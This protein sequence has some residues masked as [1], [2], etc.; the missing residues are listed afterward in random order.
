MADLVTVQ[1]EIRPQK[2]F[3]EAFLSSRA[4][5]TIGGGAAGLGKTWTLQIAP[6]RHI[7]T[8]GFNCVTFRRTMEQIKNPGSLWDKSLELYP[9][10]RLKANEQQRTWTRKGLGITLKFS[11]LQYEKNIYDHD[12]TEYCLVCW[13][14]LQ[15][16]SKKMFF[17]LLSRNRSTCGVRPY[18]LATCNPDPDSF[19]ADFLEWWI[20]QDEI[21]PDGSKNPNWG[22]P[23]KERVGKLRYMVVYEDNVIWG[24]SK[25]EIIEKHPDIFE[26]TKGDPEELIKSVTFITGTIYDNKKLLDTNA[27]YLA[28]LMALDEV[29][30]ARLLFGNWKVRVND[31][32][33]H[34]NESINNVFFNPYPNLDS[35]GYITCDAAM[36]G[37][38]L[39]TIWTWRGWKV[40]RLDIFSK[41]NQLD[42]VKQI[43]KNRA[44]FG[45]L[46][47]NVLIDQQ[48]VGGGVVKLGKYVGFSG[49]DNPIPVS[50]LK[51]DRGKPKKENYENLKTQVAYRYAERFNANEIS[52]E[53]TEGNVY[54][55]GYHGLK[56]K[57]NGNTYDIRDLIKKNYKAIK[58]I[59]SDFEG[60]K[61]INSKMDQKR[62]LKGMSPD[63]YDGSMMREYY[64][65]KNRK[66][67]VG[68]PTSQRMRGESILDRL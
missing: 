19:L 21:L 40:V 50:E 41:N 53:L 2:G 37:D 6:L 58:A 35:T 15:H 34:S 13:D 67:T 51:D 30:K 54:I 17:Y 66:I 10:F 39:S 59:D 63:F 33:L 16:F 57:I 38:D 23:I 29:E 24:D 36:F 48:G 27:G 68:N 62:I 64:A 52:F 8:K 65:L 31:T 7:N 42:L 18:V 32:C 9:M 49:Q 55:D 4:D 12:G 44:E 1:K 47:T 61:K 56:I 28:N 11:H 25:K 43:E 46:R 22:F 14:E 5:I 60:K 26:Q 45:V 20:D 3:Q